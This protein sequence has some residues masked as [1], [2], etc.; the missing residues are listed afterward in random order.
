[1]PTENEVKMV[2]D[3]NCENKIIK[4]AKKHLCIHQGYL[5]ASRGISLRLR[6]SQIGI[7]KNNI[8][9]ASSDDKRYEI[10]FK[11]NINGRVIEIENK[12]DK[13]DF[14]DL[15]TQCLNKLI[16]FRHIIKEKEE[17]W[18][19]DF[20][21]DY[22]N[23]NYFAMAELEMPEGQT[24][25]NFIPDFIKNNLVYEVPLTDTRFSS[26][27]IAD[28]RYAVELNKSLLKR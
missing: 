20:F 3:L 21:K 13:R 6:S 18:E 26:K 9:Y 4:L 23:K 25:P 10:N 15:W 2:L 5:L 22:N 17:V 14:N 28:I 7:I 11:S 19:I 12:I 27:L 8:F 1:M 16:K 24:K